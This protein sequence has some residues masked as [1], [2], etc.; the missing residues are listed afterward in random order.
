MLAIALD[1]ARLTYQDV[2]TVDYRT[3]DIV[4]AF[5]KSEADAWIA[6]DITLAEVQKNHQVR[7]LL[8]SSDLFSNRFI[9]F[10]HRLFAQKYPESLS[11]TIT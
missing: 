6:S 7:V 1:R 4:Q 10:T 5:L 9:Y 3:V 11:V 2:K 8:Y